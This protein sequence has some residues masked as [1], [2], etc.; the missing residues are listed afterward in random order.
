MTNEINYKEWLEKNRIDGSDE[1]TMSSPIPT[2]DEVDK[3]T[4]KDCLNVIIE[5]SENVFKEAEKKD[6]FIPEKHFP[7]TQINTI[8]LFYRVDENADV[9]LIPPEFNEI[10]RLI[11]QYGKRIN[12][13]ITFSAD[14]S[15]VPYKDKLEVSNFLLEKKE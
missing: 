9:G 1:W 7:Y 14:F 4:P 15:F 5:G 12:L 6:K 10:F 8:E 3:I 13:P 11:R 2:L